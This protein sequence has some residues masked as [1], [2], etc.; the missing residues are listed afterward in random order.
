M[1][2]S[3]RGSGGKGE[4][5]GGGNGKR[6]LEREGNRVGGRREWRGLRAEREGEG[7]QNGLVRGGKGGKDREKERERGVKR[8]EAECDWRGQIARG[9]RGQHLMSLL[10]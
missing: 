7:K 5:A 2:D 6:K 1:D 8:D 4:K 9:P 3:K 10:V